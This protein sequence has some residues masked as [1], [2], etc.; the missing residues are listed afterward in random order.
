MPDEDSSVDEETQS[1]LDAKEAHTGEDKGDGGK[2]TAN[3][4]QKQ[5][6][7]PDAGESH[8]LAHKKH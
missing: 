5:D 1:L 4:D 7:V 8:G 6:Q 3:D 2:T